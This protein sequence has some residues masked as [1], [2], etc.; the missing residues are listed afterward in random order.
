MKY[1]RRLL[2]GALAAGL[3]GCSSAFSPLPCT[4][5]A[6]CGAGMACVPSGP[7]GAVLACTAAADAPLRIG[8]SAALSGPSQALGE[9]MK[10][11]VTLAFDAQNAAGGVRGR[12]LLLDVR[13]DAYEPDLAE[14]NTRALLDVQPGTGPVRCP[15]TDT[16]VVAGQAPVS[17]TSLVSGPDA[18]LAILGNVGTPTMVL[19]APV[20]LET[21]TLFFGAFTGATPILRDTSAGPCHADVFNV[22]TSYADEAMAALQYFFDLG[23]PD[24]THLLSFDQDDSFGQSGYDG[25][26]AAYQT[27]EGGFTPPPPDPTNPIPRFRYTRDDVTSVP[28]AVTAASQYL[29][30]ILAAD[31]NAH[32]VGVLMTDTYGPATTFITQLRQWQYASDAEQGMDHK[33]TRLTLSFVNVS[34]VGPNALAANLASA[35]T[36]AGPNGQVPYTDGVLVSQV[37]PNYATDQ[38]DLVLAYDQAVAAS[39]QTPGFTSLEGYAAARI[40]VAGLVAHTGPFTS[41]ALIGTFEQLDGAGLGLGAESGFG[42]GDHDYS[43]SVWGTSIDATGAFQ[44]RYFWSEGTTLSLFE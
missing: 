39:G 41:D 34:F 26:V 32:T 17:T 28:A 36:I 11:G 29:A 23:V 7:S 5:D 44:D 20:S 40:F 10:L 37:V 15:T 31:G 3:A 35:G 42:P 4:A 14:S 38:S 19:S 21:G 33:G 1:T 25:L 16:S 27:L 30:S 18:A 2:P 22:R 24:F 9:G 8:M 13:D 12:P 43:K 6:D